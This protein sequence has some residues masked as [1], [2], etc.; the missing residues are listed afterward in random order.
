MQKGG[1]Y[2]N[3]EKFWCVYAGG[4]GAGGGGGLP[5]F[6]EKKRRKGAALCDSKP[7]LVCNF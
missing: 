2:L 3:F 6:L 7:I 4:G 1:R 5:D